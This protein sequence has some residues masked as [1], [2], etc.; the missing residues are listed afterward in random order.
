MSMCTIEFGLV[1]HSTTTFLLM[2][3]SSSESLCRSLSS[4]LKGCGAVTV[5]GLSKCCMC[6]RGIGNTNGSLY[7]QLFQLFQLQHPQTQLSLQA[8]LQLPPLPHLSQPHQPQPL[9]QLHL[10]HWEPEAGARPRLTL[11]NSLVP[12]SRLLRRL[13][14]VSALSLPSWLLSEMISY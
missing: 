11:L 2:R 7:Y 14:D 10:H 12:L 8:V 9:P 5:W 4:I 1:H 3:Y 6:L 13:V